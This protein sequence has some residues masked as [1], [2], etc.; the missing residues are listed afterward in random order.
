MTV[1]VRLQGHPFDLEFLAAHF[2][3]GEPRIV[4][5]DEGTF[6][7]AD[8]GHLMDDGGRLVEAASALLV[9]LNGYA[10]LADPGYRP[11][12]LGNSFVREEHT[13]H[14]DVVLHDEVRARDRVTVVQL[15]VAETRCKA[16]PV[17]ALVNGVPV[18]QPAPK[19]HADLARAVTDKDVAELLDLVGNAEVLGWDELWKTLEIIKVRVGGK[20]ALLATGWITDGELEEFG[21]AANHPDASGAAAR[22][23][24]RPPGGKVPSR[25]LSAAQGQQLIRNLARHW[26][27]SL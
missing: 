9:R 27:D 2:P 13:T 22:H 5:T 17:T 11:V 12:R 21:Y 10:V 8:L 7:T 18:P 16:Y 6:L 24:R 4:V 3:T 23:A 20:A 15:G 14:T 1:R 26:L 19:A 25:V